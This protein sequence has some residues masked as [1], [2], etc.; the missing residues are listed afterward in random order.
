MKLKLKIDLSHVINEDFFDQIRVEK[1]PAPLEIAPS[2]I[3]YGQMEALFHKVFADLKD[4]KGEIIGKR[5]IFRKS[6]YDT[7]IKCDVEN[8]MELC[9]SLINQHIP[10]CT[11]SYF[12]EDEDDNL[13]FMEDLEDFEELE[14]KESYFPEDIKKILELINYLKDKKIPQDYVVGFLIIM[15]K[16]IYSN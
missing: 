13:A 14:E 8:S 3:S 16:Y 9:Y 12:R 1:V 2:N 7:L 11:K 15:I 5:A 10:P 6:H 4:N